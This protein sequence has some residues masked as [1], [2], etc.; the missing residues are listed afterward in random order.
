MDLRS[1]ITLKIGLGPPSKL[2]YPQDTPMNSTPRFFFLDLRRDKIIIQTVI[3]VNNHEWYRVIYLWCIYDAR[4]SKWYFDNL[5]KFVYILFYQ[6]LCCDG[7]LFWT[8]E[9]M[10]LWKEVCHCF[11]LHYLSYFEW[12]TWRWNSW[13]LN[14]NDYH[15]ISF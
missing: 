9:N 2:R 15:S 6:T 8:S 1:K 14:V 3:N 10:E 7:K 4:K 12:C 11:Y 5:L 13:T